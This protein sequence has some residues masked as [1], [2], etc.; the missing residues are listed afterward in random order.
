MITGW[1]ILSMAV[2]THTRIRAV[3][4]TGTAITIP[5]RNCLLRLLPSQ[6]MDILRFF[7]IYSASLP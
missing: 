5:N 7:F 1:R 3:A 4:A 6:A 2:K